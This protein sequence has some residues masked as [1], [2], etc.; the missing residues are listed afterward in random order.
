MKHLVHIYLVSPIHGEIK[1]LGKI[2]VF[3]GTHELFLPDARKFR[4]KAARQLVDIN[5][6]EYPKMNQ[7]F[8]VFP[9]LKR[10]RRLNRL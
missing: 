2:S 3:I 6:F 5:Y 1:N 7:L 10:K 9:I 8:P 4:E